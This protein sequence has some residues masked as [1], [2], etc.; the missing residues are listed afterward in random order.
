M[1][2]GARNGLVD[3]CFFEEGLHVT[4]QMKLKL[5]GDR[6]DNIELR[7]ERHTVPPSP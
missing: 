1:R 2:Q 4:S 3:Q 5:G 6:K 7:E